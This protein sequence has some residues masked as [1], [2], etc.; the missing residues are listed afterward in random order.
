MSE[1]D[2]ELSNCPSVAVHFARSFPY[3]FEERVS[4][5]I[6]SKKNQPTNKISYSGI[7]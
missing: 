5:D 6:S 3:A 1:L 4:Q 7:H 2:T